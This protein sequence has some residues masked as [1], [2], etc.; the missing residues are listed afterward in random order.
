VVVAAV[1]ALPVLTVLMI[2]E[3][4]CSHTVA[5]WLAGD[6][7]ARFVLVEQTATD[8]CTG[9]N[10]YDSARIGPGA[11]AIVNAAGVIGTQLLAWGSLLA[12]RARPP[13]LLRVLLLELLG[14][15][16]LGD[17]VFQVVQGFEA[18]VPVRE[19]VGEGLGYTD[20]SAVVSF[21]AQATGLPIPLVAAALLALVALD[22]LALAVATTR[23]LRRAR[24][25]SGRV[26]TVRA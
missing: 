3:H 13:L 4:E 2:V 10:L 17:L 26:A 19:P 1:L 24:A 22:L 5:A 6:P 20:A 8:S 15:T 7:T 12:L 25:R 11:N 16:V 23:V 21:A 14:I 18:G 9:C